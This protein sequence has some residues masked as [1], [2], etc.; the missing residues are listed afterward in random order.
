MNA[1][2]SKEIAKLISERLIK[3]L[4]RLKQQYSESK[5]RIGFFYID[6]ILPVELANN[7]FKVFPLKSEM[8][9]LKSMREYKYVTAQMN[10]HNKL[11]EDVLYAFQHNDV[12]EVISEITGIDTLLADESL[13]AGGLSLMEHDNFL[14]PHLDNS[15]DAKRERWRVLYLLYY[16]TPDW[17]LENGGHL[18]IWPHG[19]KN[20]PLVIESKFNRLAVMAT[21]QDS[22]HSVNKVQS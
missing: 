17:Q 14:N 8:K 15:H 6:D 21:H 5:D 3:E 11:L 4:P 1:Q 22:W 16:V 10:Q 7:C 18:E 12:V 19:P 20:D 9:Q 13:Y 2:Y